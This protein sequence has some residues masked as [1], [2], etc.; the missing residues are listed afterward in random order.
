[1]AGVLLY[2]Y[3]LRKAG[4]MGLF[5]IGC[6]LLSTRYTATLLARIQEQ[7]PH[8]RSYSDIV[9]ASF[10]R[11][12]ASITSV[13]LFLELL[14]GAC[15]AFGVIAGD[16]LHRLYPLL[17]S[18][19]Y[20]AMFFVACLPTVWM[21]N[22]RWLAWLGTVGIAALIALF[23]TLIYI[24]VSPD[25]AHGLFHPAPTDL[26]HVDGIFATLG[27]II[28]AL[29][30]HTAIPSIRASMKNPK[31]F[32]R[33][34]NISFL[35][36]AIMYIGGA[37][38]GYLTFGTATK[39]EISLNFPPGVEVSIVMWMLVA[40]R[41]CK[42]ALVLEPVAEGAV[43]IYHMFCQR[44]TT[45]YSAMQGDEEEG[46]MTS[47]KRVMLNRLL[48]S[49]VATPFSPVS[50]GEF[51]M[52]HSPSTTAGTKPRCSACH[53]ACCGPRMKAG[54][55][56]SALAAIAAGIALSFPDV[57]HIISLTGSLLCYYLCF[58]VP[59]EA[60]IKLLHSHISKCSFVMARS[61]SIL[62]AFLGIA[63]FVASL[64]VGV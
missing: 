8:L 24:G 61:I 59:A 26:L 4:W 49:G 6:A 41:F 27:V 55:L 60:Y 20:T 63:G 19:A 42:F 3:V 10:G 18:K 45:R 54:F 12:G 9:L 35:L 47:P 7:K 37:A 28:T 25:I 39:Q 15:S 29:A 44:G 33:A 2:P 1:M 21:P 13:A 30:G 16:Q 51:H 56:R 57:D 46:E 17:S 31:H 11:T 5:M 32:S 14:V 48:S 50:T 58:I 22:L 52:L 43:S 62:G 64:I 23:G 34:L 40:N 53:R 36:T 38:V